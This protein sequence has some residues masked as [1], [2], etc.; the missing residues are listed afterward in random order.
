MA[1]KTNQTIER[2]GKSYPLLGVN[3]ALSPM[4]RADGM[5]LSVAVRLTPYRMGEDG[6]EVLDDA[7]Q[8][9]VFGDATE[10][11]RQDPA[12]AEFL[13]AI[14]AAGQVFIDAKGL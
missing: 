8:A 11:A 10:A 6:P 13:R 2:N 14:E 4:W 12:V 5:G 7:V 1:L 9:V 3:L